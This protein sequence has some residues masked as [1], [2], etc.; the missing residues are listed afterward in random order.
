MEEHEL[1]QYALEHG[2]INM[3]YVQ[4][5]VDMN[6]RKELLEKHP[7]AIWEGK[8]GKWR[9]YLHDQSSRRMIKRSTRKS[10]EDAVVEYL[11]SLKE[12]QPKTFDDVYWIWRKVQDELVESPNTPVRYD[13][14]YERYF[15]Q[16]DFSTREIIAITEDDVKI[17]MHS[18]IK[19]MNLCKKSAKTLFGYLSRVFRCAKMNKLIESNPTEYLSAKDFYKYCTPS[20]RSQKPQIV[21][22]FDMAKLN[23]EFEKDF[24]NKPWYIP[25]YAVVLASLTGM[26]VGELSAL[27]WEDI[28]NDRIMIRNSEKYNRKTKEYFISSTK[29]DKIRGFPITTAIE[30]L[31][32]SIK[33]VEI[34]YGYY[35]EWVFANENGRVHAPVIS[36]CIKNKCR[37]AGI[38]EKG[39]HALRKT[40]NS[41]M[42]HNGVPGTVASSL[43]GHT[44]EVN[45]EYYTF[46]VSSMEEKR[47]IISRVNQDM[48]NCV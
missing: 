35:C 28:D 48:R 30:S 9:T 39:I 21:S 26:R 7:Y 42:R 45:K 20:S 27:R 32:K 16:N 13:T 38:S 12:N 11:E 24:A 33:K 19:K 22:D 43:M 1:L 46:D 40:V 4:E 2:M 23:H 17:F 18:S 5:Q 44:E 14:D 15:K 31:F 8:D 10:V 3:S 41:K 47:K 29:N 6:K 34:K 36:S 37:M 25:T